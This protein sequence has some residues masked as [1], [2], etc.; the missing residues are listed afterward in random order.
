VRGALRVVAIAALLS[1]VAAGCDWTA[2]LGGPEH[3]SQSVDAGIQLS[4]VAGLQRRWR[5][6][7]PT[8]DTRP[9]SMFSTPVTWKG[10]IFVGTNSGYLVALDALTGKQK[11]QRDFGFQPDL[12]CNAAGISSS[13]V[14]RDDGNGN[15]L[16]YLNAPD[17]YLYELDGLTGNTVWRSV[18]Q[19]PSTTVNDSYAWASPTLANGRVYVGIASGCDTPFVRGALKAYDQQTG[20]L[21]A[22]GWTIPSGY[23]GAGIWTSA[24]AD[25]NGVYVTT[26]S[27]TTATE[28]EHPQTVSNDFDQYSIL[29]LDPTTL[30][31]VGKWPA[32]PTDVGDPDFGSSPILFTATIGGVNRQMAGACNK[33]GNFYAVRTDTMKLVWSRQV[34]TGA[35]AG[36]VACLGGGV[37][38][39]THL[40]V[41]GNATTV[42][43]TAVAGSVRQLDPATGSIVWETGLPAN[44]LGTG[45]A[46]SAGLLAYAGT[47]WNEGAG[48]GVY[49][50]D[51][52]TGHVVRTLDDV[53]EYPEFAQV[54]WSDGRLYATNTDSLVMWSP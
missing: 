28:T 44:P 5:W 47:D 25:A 33:D 7:P 36:E 40:F 53:A 10:T 29:K 24:A 39:G 32:P 1:L 15:A 37:W 8:S 3:H 14:V 13:P 46:N 16:V 51:A 45:S 35:D 30:A 18:V 27:T 48:N 11:W 31:V 34:G 49:V 9:G 20:A 4:G 17:G 42:G 54:V 23:I 12:T 2:Y 19:I 41:A 21:L 26:G 6:Q 22:T 38:D 52:S 50:L 43:A